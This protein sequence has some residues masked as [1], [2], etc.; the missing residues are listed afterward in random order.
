[1]V[2]QRAALRDL[3]PIARPYS[4]Q[5]AV[6]WIVQTILFAIIAIIVTATMPRQVGAV[7]RQL[8]RRPLASFGWGALGSFIVI[9]VS[10]VILTITLI[11]LL[12]VI[13]GVFLGLPL[14]FLFTGTAVAV[15]IGE[16][17]WEEAA[18]V[19][20]SCWPLWSAWP[21][22]ASCASCPSS[23]CSPWYW[24]GSRPRRLG[25]GD[26]RVAARPP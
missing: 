8:R 15:A 17:S 11:G 10:I 2:Q 25:P 20:T 5:A 19:T 12:L 26:R 13:P 16:W 6:P 14:T 21:F 7:A 23:V 1:M 18:S 3:E 24:H 22:S 9:P 4:V